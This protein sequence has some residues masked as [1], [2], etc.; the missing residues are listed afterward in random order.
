MITGKAELMSIGGLAKKTPTPRPSG[1]GV[2]LE[3]YSLKCLISNTKRKYVLSGSQR[4]R[5]L[6]IVVL[7]ECRDQYHGNSLR[8]VTFD[9]LAWE[10]Q[11]HFFKTAVVRYLE[12]IK[13]NLFCSSQF[14][15][16][17]NGTDKLLRSFASRIAGMNGSGQE[18]RFR[19]VEQ[20]RV[21]SYLEWKWE[22][23]NLGAVY[24]E[25][26]RFSPE[27]VRGMIQFAIK[28]R[29]YKLFIERDK[30]RKAS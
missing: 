13:G 25:I 1:I 12:I 24:K 2:F 16:C 3:G 6:E 27:G 21:G 4:E 23:V 15:R 17:M 30:E 5:K 11:D 18:V 20:Y 28:Y 10:L 19:K 29:A 22:V 9:M 26:N 14:K 8:E 7:E